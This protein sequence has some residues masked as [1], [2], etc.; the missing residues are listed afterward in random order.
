MKFK[1]TAIALFTGIAL[2]LGAGSAAAHAALISSDPAD[3]SEIDRGPDAVSLTFNEAISPNFPEL[4]VVGPDGNRWS[5]GD[6]KVDDKI[7]SVAVG[8]LGPAGEYKIAFRVTS[9][10]GHVVNGIRTFTLV[11]EGSGTP[12]EAVKQDSSEAS[13]GINIWWF[14]G[15]AGVAVAIALGVVLL[16]PRKD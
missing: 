11:Q 7:V 4:T 15:A 13:D 9:A 12:G 2:L 8:D 3:Q 14:V 1:A 6:A 10:D 16:R 5:K